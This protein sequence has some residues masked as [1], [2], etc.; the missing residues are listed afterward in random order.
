MEEAKVCMRMW[1]NGEQKTSLSCVIRIYSAQPVHRHTRRM[2][3][4]WQKTISNVNS[5]EIQTDSLWVF[6]K[7]SVLFSQTALHECIQ[8]KIHCVV[9]APTLSVSVLVITQ[10]HNRTKQMDSICIKTRKEMDNVVVKR[11]VHAICTAS[12]IDL[13]PAHTQL[14]AFSTEC[15]PRL[16]ERRRIKWK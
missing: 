1:V 13:P 3:A 6:H 16:A 4:E 5:R 12:P 15:D 10:T 11:V 8:I 14:T 7:F 2:Q 9:R